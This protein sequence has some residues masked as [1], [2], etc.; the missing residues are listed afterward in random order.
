MRSTRPRTGTPRSSTSPAGSPANRRRHR[1]RT[2]PR[3]RA[4]T[5][6][7]AAAGNDQQTTNAALYPA[8]LSGKY[9]NILAVSAVDAKDDAGTFSTSGHYVDVCAPGLVV[10][11]LAGLHGFTKS[12]RHEFRRAIRHRIGRRCCGPVTR[13]STPCRRSTGSRRPPI[14]RRSRR[15]T[16]AWGCGMVNPNL[17]V[18]SVADDS[19]T[20][21]PSAAAKPLPARGAS[22]APSRHLQHVAVVAEAHGLRPGTS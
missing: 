22:A 7:V 21:R 12:E 8:A 11:G 16:R 18:T 9:P 4:D 15:P 6:I 2:R 10:E 13:T 17:A 19:D 1:G 3:R 5:V 14:R 20:S